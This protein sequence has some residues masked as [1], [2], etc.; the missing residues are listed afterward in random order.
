MNTVL[1]WFKANIGKKVS[2]GNNIPLIK[3]LDGTLVA[4]KEG[5]L[6]FEHTVR[7]DFVN[8]VG[9]LHG[10]IASTFMDDVIGATV[11]ALGK[12]NIYVSLNLN[13]D[14][15]SPAKLGEKIFVSAEV[16]RNGENIIHL[17]AKIVN[18]KGKLIAKAT[19]NMAKTNISK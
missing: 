12:P 8:P 5:S 2:E 4:A 16:I 9:I 11:F 18:E 7:E 10:G 14:F 6:T 15:M 13:V 1:D 3:W 17:H 19:S